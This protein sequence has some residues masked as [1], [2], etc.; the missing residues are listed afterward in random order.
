MGQFNKSFFLGFVCANGKFKHYKNT[1]ISWSGSEWAVNEWRFLVKG[2]KSDFVILEELRLWLGAGKIT[3][4]RD[5]L[6]FAITSWRTCKDVVIPAFRGGLVGF[7]ERQF[8]TWAES[9]ENHSKR[10]GR[11]ERY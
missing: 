2:E 6:E 8:E 10:K 7:R 11:N 9:I 5:V 3:K 4:V 1:K